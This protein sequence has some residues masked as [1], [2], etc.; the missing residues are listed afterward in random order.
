MFNHVHEPHLV[1]LF[2]DQAGVLFGSTTG[3][4][5]YPWSHQICALTSTRSGDCIIWKAVWN[6]LSCSLC[7]DISP[8]DSS[9]ATLCIIFPVLCFSAKHYDPDTTE[10]ISCG[11]QTLEELLSWKR[12]E[13]NPFNVAAVPLAP[14][15]PPLASCPL[16]TLVS[17]DMMG[18]YLDDRYGWIFSSIITATI[19]VCWL[20]YWWNTW[21]INSSAFS[22]YTL[23]SCN[24]IQKSLQDVRPVFGAI[25]KL[26][27]DA[28]HNFHIWRMNTSFQSHI[29]VKLDPVYS[30]SISIYDI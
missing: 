23:W 27:V 3:H 15:E 8:H 18:G 20:A 28:E 13:A 2:F 25:M 4:R 19:T 12:S 17:H 26:G 9:P 29:A 21:K 7:V 22:S 24:V 11:L 30:I 14:R 6:H 16:R 10:P 1:T 5:Q